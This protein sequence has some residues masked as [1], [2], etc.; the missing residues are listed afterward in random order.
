MNNNLK[1]RKVN[2]PSTTPKGGRDRATVNSPVIQKRASKPTPAQKAMLEGEAKKTD[3]AVKEVANTLEDLMVVSR[4]DDERDLKHVCEAAEHLTLSN[5]QTRRMYKRYTEKWL[6]YV[7]EKGVTNECDDVALQDWF[8][9]LRG[10]YAPSTLWVVYACLNSYFQEKYSVN[11][12]TKPRL[13]RYLKGQSNTYVC[14]KSKTFTPEDVDSI[15]MYC[16]NSEDEGDH[17]LGVGVAL[18]YLLHPVTHK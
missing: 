8:K 16:Q 3:K 13:Q 10:V 15:L 7:T 11:L 12:N 14:S 5:P 6:A 1:F 2:S 9:T 18:M 4:P 17:L